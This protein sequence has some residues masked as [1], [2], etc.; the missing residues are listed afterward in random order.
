MPVLS[1][2]PQPAGVPAGRWALRAARCGGRAL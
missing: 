2:R 1:A